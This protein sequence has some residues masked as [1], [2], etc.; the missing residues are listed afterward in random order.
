MERPCVRDR[1]SEL[2]WSYGLDASRSKD[3]G[4]GSIRV[5]ASAKPGKSNS[6]RE[7]CCAVLEFSRDEA[8]VQPLEMQEMEKR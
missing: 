4:H 7:H 5:L 3:I 1:N 8:N 6:Y 2:T